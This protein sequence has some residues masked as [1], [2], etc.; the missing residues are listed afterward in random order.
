MKRK[1]L[2]FVLLLIAILV[3][4]FAY[5]RIDILESLHEFTQPRYVQLTAKQAAG[6]LSK[7]QL[8]EN[9]VAVIAKYQAAST[10]WLKAIHMSKF[11]IILLI[12]LVLI[13]AVIIV[14]IALRSNQRVEASANSSASSSG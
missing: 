13:E 7:E 8:A 5:V 10:L 4:A 14:V 2:A 12:A 3:S 1:I 9:W 6:V 11:I